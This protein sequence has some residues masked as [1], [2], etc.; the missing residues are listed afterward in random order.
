MVSILGKKIRLVVVVKDL[1]VILDFDLIYNDY[2][3]LIVFS[4]MVFLG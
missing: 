2:I 3:V 1:G 4:C